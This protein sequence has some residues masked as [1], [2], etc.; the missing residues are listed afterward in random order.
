VI[1]AALALSLALAADAGV[2]PAAVRPPAAVEA[3]ARAAH[4]EGLSRLRAGHADES[5]PY[6]QRAAAADP[7]SAVFAT[8]LGFALGKAG[9]TA[10]AEATLRAAIEKDPRRFYA[11]VNLADL[12]A[13]DPSRWERRD[14][15]VAFL[16]KGL[17]ALKDDR[18]GR[19]NLLLRVANFERS[20]GRTAA[21]RARLEPLLAE[22]A[23]PLSPAQRKRVLDELD[24]VTLDERAH[25]LEPWP[26]PAVGDAERRKADEAA[27]ALAAGQPEAARAAA[28]TLVRAKP[29]STWQRPRFLL[30]SALEA[31]G[32][33]DEAARELEIAVNLAPSDA[34]AWRALG[35]V[36]AER[37]GALEADRADEALRN[38]LAL[39]PAW[40][41]LRDL[42]A[43]LARRRGGRAAEGYAAP[44]SGPSDRARALY[45][46]AQDWIEVGDPTGQGRELVEK[47]LVDSPGYVAAA[48][49]AYALKGDV[50]AA[51]ITALWDDGPALWSLV[52]GVRNVAGARGADRANAADA[53][54]RRWFDRAVELDVQEARWE[55]ALAR[56]AAGEKAGALND[57]VEYVAFEPRPAHLAEARA[58]RAG[59]AGGEA[60]PA[61]ERVARIRLLEDRPD[62][63]LR[64][65][66]G[67]CAPGL[68]V[69][70]LVALGL[71]HEYADRRG[72]ARVCYEQA[73]A[74][75]PEDVTVLS[76]LARLDARLDGREL[77][78]AA[79]APLERAA[80]HD[81]AAAEWSLARLDASAGEEARALERVGRALSLAGRSVTDAEVWLPAAR[82]A[83]A[84]WSTAGEAAARDAREQK[85][86]LALGGGGLAFA[87]L[88]LGVR[89]RLRGLTLARAV[90]RHP[91]LFPEVSRALGE[92]RH[93]V[94]KHR[95]GALGL[96]G[97]QGAARE[98]LARALLEP[99]PTSTIVADTHARLVGAARGQGVDLRPLAREPALGPLA[100]DLSLAERLVA[101]A[102]MDARRLLEI[103]ARLRGPRA[104]ALAE[105]LRQ[106][107][108][109]RL[110]AAELSAW[111]AAIEASAR[112]EGV[113][114]RAPA[115][116]L[117]ELDV[118]FPV[119]SGALH[120]IFANLL[121]N[122]QAAV[123][124]AEDGHVIVR[125]E[126]SRDVTGRQVATLLVGDSA[127]GTLTLD[128]IEARESGRGLAIVR[129]LVRTWSGH[130]VIR[131]EPAPY[132]KV[133]GACFPL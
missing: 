47:A 77:A 35:R 68:P 44:G 122:A 66:G 38:A 30:G 104:E 9:R 72:A 78:S 31:L 21:A 81:V 2:E 32:R 20:V 46:Q 58:L 90:A 111:I 33:V 63:A 97:D 94:L 89:R 57:L 127:T 71:V 113:A 98:E 15:I 45:E 75:A 42:R 26:A 133:V 93:D 86:R 76:R 128:A 6:F 105:L 16:D 103:D 106:G 80:R 18:K 120:A 19:F 23:E 48:V 25:A 124:S 59:L 51:T 13:D 123:G 110:G 54:T 115:L 10:E 91:A 92:L 22:R 100:A 3:D 70:R 64:A 112:A 125:V 4:T 24:S 108:R 85:R 114:W 7:A 84:R 83:H 126:R 69:E 99:T 129:D 65:L 52:Q 29:T 119:E 56:A 102:P 28:I 88:A 43:Q 121:R 50:A 5:L 53:L 12:L 74:R 79:R 61:P 82:E 39:E 34:A 14:A 116:T 132:R 107:P 109:T 11:Y 1:A 62:A 37:G 49:T 17:A 87:A 36:L 67:P 118:D 73:A 96:A 130:L 60:R 27:Q 95:A 131:D 41:D 117:A 55:R 40:G 8:D 101:A